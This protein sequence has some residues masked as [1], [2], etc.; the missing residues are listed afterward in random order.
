M[1]RVMSDAFR[2]HMQV[3]GSDNRPVGAILRIVG[4]HIE[5][6]MEPV[7]RIPLVWVAR[8]EGDLVRLDR[9][10][11]QALETGRQVA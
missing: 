2:A 1:S 10:A 11:N 5:L 4:R 6:A 7:L 8:V 9:P 3:V